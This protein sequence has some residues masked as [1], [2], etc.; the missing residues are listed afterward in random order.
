M[1][2]YWLSSEL[3]FY[4][5]DSN[6]IYDLND[7]DLYDELYEFGGRRLV[8]GESLIW[9]KWLSGTMAAGKNIILVSFDRGS[10]EDSNLGGHFNSL[11]EIST[12]PVVKL[13]RIVGRFH[14]RIG[15]RYING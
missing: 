5:D 2:H 13:G 1:D 4:D 7:A 10:L 11:G 8:G 9:N 6:N 3:S 15:Y 14:W 12:E